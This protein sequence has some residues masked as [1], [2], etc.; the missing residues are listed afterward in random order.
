MTWHLNVTG[1]W[2]QAKGFN[3]IKMEYYECEQNW[4]MFS[5][6][7]LGEHDDEDEG[8]VQTPHLEKEEEEDYGRWEQTRT[9]L[10]GIKI[11][12][13][14]SSS[15]LQISLIVRSWGVGGIFS[16]PIFT[17]GQ[18]NVVAQRWRSEWVRERGNKSPND[19]PSSHHGPGSLRRPSSKESGQKVGTL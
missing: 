18:A 3:K 4:R 14:L 13:V 17:N 9:I 6:S 16:L 19:V 5:P 2:M 8:S 10:H 1:W 11:I 15:L 7:P 12:H